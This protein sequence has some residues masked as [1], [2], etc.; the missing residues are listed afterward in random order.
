MITIRLAQEAD[1]PEILAI[2]EPYIKETSITFEY[3]TPSL[4]E[5]KN[6]IRQISSD[7][8]YLVCLSEDRIIGYA[9]AHRHM[10][11][12]AYQWN[13]E[14]SVYLHNAYLGCGIGK[15]LYNT[16]IEILQLQNVRN[17]YG[18]AAFPNENSEKL[19]EHLGFQKLG[20]YHN[21]GYKFG[22]WHDVMWFEKAIR[23]HDLDP[24]PFLSIQEV[25][26]EAIAEILN[27]HNKTLL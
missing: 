14:L 3:E 17:V 10:E 6:R 9:Y 15:T 21:T 7:Y 18:G 25:D 2:Y 20:V 24:Q 5:F 26:K 4:D 23:S 13:A 16:L 1:A 27:R 19:H 11:R 12:A 8:P 22:A